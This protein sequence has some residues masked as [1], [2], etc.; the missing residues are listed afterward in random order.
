MS[1][2]QNTVHLVKWL[3]KADHF[4]CSI[5][6]QARH[7]EVLA[8]P[9]SQILWCQPAKSMACP[10]GVCDA[11]GCR[12]W[13]SDWQCITLNTVQGC[14]DTCPSL[15]LCQGLQSFSLPSSVQVPLSKHIFKSTDMQCSVTTVPYQWRL[16]RLSTI[17]AGGSSGSSQ[18]NQWGSHASSESVNHALQA[19]GKADSCCI[20]LQ[21][22]RT[23]YL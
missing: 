10:H 12:A 23:V 1:V 14:C 20:I 3:S 6:T 2:S 13:S 19:T 22:L 18:H 15:A 17:E 11:C 5:D 21:P 16:V 4:R 8:C 9:W 7:T